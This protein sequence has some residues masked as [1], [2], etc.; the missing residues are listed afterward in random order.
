VAPGRFD[1]DVIIAGGGPA[2]AATAIA[3]AQR[4][5]RVHLF[6]QT[7]FSGS[8]PGETLHPGVEPLLGQLGLAD[9]F[10]AT[11]GARH[12]GIW[13]SWGGRKQFQPYGTDQDGAWHGFQVSRATF[14]QLLL[15]YAHEQ[16]VEVRQP[17][18]VDRV[19]LAQENEVRVVTGAGPFS[20]GSSSTGQGGQAGSR[21]GSVLPGTRG[22]RG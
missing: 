11:V 16:G 18:A 19:Q 12:S 22:R 8:R 4:G 5:L 3:F 17:C 7:G 13:L 6:E 1:T 14:D 9:R 20:A 15:D 2:G 10:Q 21:A